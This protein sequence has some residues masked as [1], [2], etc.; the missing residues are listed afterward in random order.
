MV[1]ELKEKM[2]LIGPELPAATAA[3]DTS[4]FADDVISALVNLGYKKN[5]AEEAVRK[6]SDK[7]PGS[8]VEEM[9]RDALGMLMKH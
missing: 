7:R 6:V 5:L 3:R 1:L 8:S 4:S 9:I 2:I